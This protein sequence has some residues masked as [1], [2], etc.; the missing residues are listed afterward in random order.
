MMLKRGVIHS[1]CLNKTGADFVDL[2]PGSSWVFFPCHFWCWNKTSVLIWLLPKQNL[3]FR[4]TNPPGLGSFISVSGGRRSQCFWWEETTL[5][6]SQLYSLVPNHSPK[7][8]PKREWSFLAD[9]P[10]LILCLRLT[11]LSWLPPPALIQ[12]FHSAMF[13][14]F[15]SKAVLF[16]S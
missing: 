15:F 11:C 8:Q 16:Y 6:Q 10:L 9:M 4:G 7:A 2:N 3:K 5:A 12:V 1:S 14:L 13:I